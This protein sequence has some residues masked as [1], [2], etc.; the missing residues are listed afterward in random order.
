MSVRKWWQQN[1]Q[2]E[3]KTQKEEAGVVLMI[4]KNKSKEEP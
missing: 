2:R 1:T 4:G 3:K